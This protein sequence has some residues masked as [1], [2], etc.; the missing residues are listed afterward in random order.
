MKR[1]EGVAAVFNTCSWRQSWPVPSACDRKASAEQD[2]HESAGCPLL[3]NFVV[4]LV[5]GFCEQ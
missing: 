1:G 4:K 5:G 2:K 3:A